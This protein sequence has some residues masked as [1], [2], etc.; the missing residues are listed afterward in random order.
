MT[1]GQPEGMRRRQGWWRIVRSI[2]AYLQDR[3]GEAPVP[4]TVQ[5]ILGAC[6]DTVNVVARPLR[7]PVPVVASGAG[8]DAG[9][10]GLPA[11]CVV[12]AGLPRDDLRPGLASGCGTAAA[13][14]ELLAGET[15]LGTF[16][17][18]VG[19]EPTNNHAERER[20]LGGGD[21]IT[22]PAPESLL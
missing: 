6:P 14:R 21:L 15:H 18:A 9:P 12:A 17:R 4:K 20:R 2:V 13:C 5:A 22:N 10:V 1:P 3:G 16:V 11:P 8:R 19:V 7:R